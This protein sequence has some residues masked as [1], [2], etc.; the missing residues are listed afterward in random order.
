MWA[1]FKH[2]LRRMRWQICGWPF[3][4]ILYVLLMVFFYPNM[5]EMGEMLDQY[6]AMFPEAMLAFFKNISAI[7]TPLGYLDVYFFSYMHLIIGILAISGGANLLVGD[8]EK[9]LLDLVLA[10]PV[11]RTGLFCGRL[12][13]LFTA[14]AIILLTGWLSWAIPAERVSLNLTWAQLLRPF[15]SLFAVLVLFA[16]LALFFSLLLPAVRLANM[17]TGAL[18][19][20]NYLLMGLSNLNDKL[21]QVLKYTP[22]NYYQGGAAVEGLNGS[23]LFGLLAAAVLI[24]GVAWVLFLRRDIRVGGERSW[25][26][27]ALR[28]PSRAKS[29]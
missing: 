14:L 18:L 16:A 21:Q 4:I 20:G 7:N 6:L 22:L 17:L 28:L 1:E 23:W 12:L 8:E 26:L 15:I 3:G 9:G 5:A 24:T 25:T 2:T 13:A 27:S 29:S 11:S 10:Q 19:V